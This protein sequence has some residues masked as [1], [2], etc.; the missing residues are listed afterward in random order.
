[1]TILYIVTEVEKLV[2]LQ[3]ESRVLGVYSSKALAQESM[4][5]YILGVKE[6]AGSDMSW[7]QEVTEQG[8][9]LTDTQGCN[10]TFNIVC[11]NLDE[12]L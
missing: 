1:M 12:A 4:V 2:D 10:Y 11:R 9:T 8:L 7:S 3:P 6:M 5:K